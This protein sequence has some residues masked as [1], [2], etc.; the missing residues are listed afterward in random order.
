VNRTGAGVGGGLFAATLLMVLLRQRY[1]RWWFDFALQLARF[2][3]RVT[4]YHL[5]ELDWRRAMV[6]GRN[7][8]QQ[9]SPALRT[10]VISLGPLMSD[11]T[12][13]A[14]P[15]CGGQDGT[16]GPGRPPCG[17]LPRCGHPEPSRRRRPL[18]LGSLIAQG[19]RFRDA[20]TRDLR[21][22]LGVRFG[23]RLGGMTQL[24]T[25]PDHLRR[26]RSR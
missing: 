6:V 23:G 9:M 12:H 1:P 16:I 13:G 20:R 8:L 25:S 19:A 17:A 7:G 24:A 15:R 2:S 22:R 14:R 21:P 5:C 10:F 11:S 18:G 26:P 4:A 3:A